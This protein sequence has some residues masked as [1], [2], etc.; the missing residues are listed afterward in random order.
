MLAAWLWAGHYFGD[1][2]LVCCDRCCWHDGLSLG[3]L[4]YGEMQQFAWYGL[5]SM[6]VQIIG[7]DEK[8]NMM[9]N[10]HQKIFW[11]W[12]CVNASLQCSQHGFKALAGSNCHFPCRRLRENLC[13][14]MEVWKGLPQDT[15]QNAIVTIFWKYCELLCKQEDN[16]LILF[17]L[18]TGLVLIALL[19]LVIQDLPTQIFSWLK[20]AVFPLQNFGS[21]LRSR[22]RFWS[23]FLKP[24]HQYLHVVVYG[25]DQV[26]WEW[27]RGVLHLRSRLC[28]RVS[29]E[30]WPGPGLQGAPG[31]NPPTNLAFHWF[32]F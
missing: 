22:S 8:T 5:I 20:E 26:G 28:H 21:G 11:K 13:N 2:Y 19:V 31:I 15:L 27:Q 18:V 4:F 17:T 24:L 29:A 3:S 16:N 10:I 6:L 14:E 30:A 7:T 1:S 25:W 9:W 32:C 23:G 12:K